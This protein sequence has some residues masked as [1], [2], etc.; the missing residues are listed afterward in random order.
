MY[1]D[2]ILHLSEQYLPNSSPPL[3]PKYKT[4]QKIETFPTHFLSLIMAPRE[5]PKYLQ[6]SNYHLSLGESNYVA[7]FQDKIAIGKVEMDPVNG[8]LRFAKRSVFLPP[9]VFKSF[10][11]CLNRAYHCFPHVADGLPLPLRI[12]TKIWVRFLESLYPCEHEMSIK[13]LF[14]HPVSELPAK[15][16]SQFGPLRLDWPYCLGGNSETGWWIFFFHARFMFIW[17]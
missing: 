11:K 10:S 2:E 6:N 9:S 15:S 4:P 13:K 17:V 8:K 1:H 12:A 14:Y 16:Y 5:S 3:S 7:S